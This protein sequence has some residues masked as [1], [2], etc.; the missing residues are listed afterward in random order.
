MRPTTGPRPG[1]RVRFGEVLRHLH[2][3]PAGGF[4]DVNGQIRDLLTDN[5][6]R[7]ARRT[8]NPTKRT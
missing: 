5:A 6:V 7:R 2:S 8:A 1:K 3:I 4:G